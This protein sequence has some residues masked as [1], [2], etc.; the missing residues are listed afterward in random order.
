[1]LQNAALQL[2]KQ[3]DSLAKQGDI[4]RAIATYRTAKTW[5][6]DLDFE[7]KIRAQ[8][9]V[10]VG[11]AEALAKAGK[12]DSAIIAY[13]KAL[14]LDKSLELDPEQDAK[15]IAVGAFMREGIRLGENGDAAGAEAAFRKA[16]AMD[17]SLP[18][19][20][21]LKAQK[22]AVN[23]LI[24]QALEHLSSEDFD[25]AIT[26]FRQV[27]SLALAVDISEEDWPK[28][29]LQL[30]LNGFAADVLRA[31]DLAVEVDP[32]P[33]RWRSRRGL[34]RAL[35]G[36]REGAIADFQAYIDW[37]NTTHAVSKEALENSIQSRQAWLDSLRAGKNPFTPEKIEE[38]KNGGF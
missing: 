34:A 28:L 15:H 25:K 32:L 23:S 27:S 20:P 21:E 14:D 24:E 35:A 31:C 1:M 30:T 37:A 6:A 11:E 19:D 3:A 18:L 2:V 17:P 26:Q 5:N 13:Q 16:L 8:Q 36:D 29:C 10:T 33:G 12:I 7:P 4:K 38:L 9:F 22:L